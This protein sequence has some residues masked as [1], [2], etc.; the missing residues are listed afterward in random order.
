M[1]G[2]HDEEFHV[3][4]KNVAA[5]KLNFASHLIHYAPHIE[6]LV[7]N[8]PLQMPGEMRIVTQKLTAPTLDMNLQSALDAR[9]SSRDF[10]GRSISVGEL[11]RL[12]YVATGVRET[13]LS[14]STVWFQRNAPN[15]GGLGSIEA[16]PIVLNVEGI[17]QGI[18]HFD[19]ISHEFVLIVQGDFRQWLEKDVLFQEEFSRAAVAIVLV[20]C[21]S[22]LRKK[23]GLRGYRSVLIDAGHCSENIYLAATALSLSVCATTGFVDDEIDEALRLDGVDRA[24]VLVLLVGPRAMLH[25]SK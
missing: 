5:A 18:F 14:R 11:W 15:S 22:R 7:S 16:F 2:K 8:A 9:R 17:E 12:C 21:F 13:I 10:N 24:S 23:Y 25:P 20:G 1:I 4:S 3:A 19:S 6:N